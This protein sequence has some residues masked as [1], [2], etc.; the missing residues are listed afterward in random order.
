[1][2]RYAVLLMLLAAAMS[3][4]TDVYV[5]PGGVDRNPGS[6]ARPVRTL[7]RARQAVREIVG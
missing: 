1:M 5:S 2:I 3:A 7:E 6:T 4:A